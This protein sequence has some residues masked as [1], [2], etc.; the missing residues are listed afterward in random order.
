MRDGMKDENEILDGLHKVGLDKLTIEKEIVPEPSLTT[1]RRRFTK[2]VTNAAIIRQAVMSRQTCPEC[3]ARLAPAYRS[4]DHKTRQ[5]DGGTG[6][7][8][9]HDFTHPYCQSGHKE[10]AV[11][12]AR[13]AQQS[14]I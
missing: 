4:E 13:Q 14:Q 8:D 10:K 6:S 3:K 5:Q 9:N 7:I 11:Y 2:T 12:E 1:K